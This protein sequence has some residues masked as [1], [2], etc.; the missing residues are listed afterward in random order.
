MIESLDLVCVLKLKQKGKRTRNII[1]LFAA[2]QLEVWFI[3][4]MVPFLHN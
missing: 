4:I 2:Q 3:S 1:E